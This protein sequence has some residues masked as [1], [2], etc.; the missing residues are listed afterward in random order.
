MY[1]TDLKYTVTHEWAGIE[2]KTGIVTVG[3]GEYAVKQLSDIVFLELPAVGD[4]LKKGEPFGAI[5]SVK[6]VFDLNSPVT[7]EVVEVNQALS[8]NL[9]LLQTDP[10]GQCWM[11]RI[12]AE[13]QEEIQALMN[14]GDYED[15]I[16]KGQGKH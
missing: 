9:D 13:N 14:A 2:E 6:A 12:K 10:Y 16:K 5:E 7:G 11:V 8:D 4:K 15:F 3:I 1:P